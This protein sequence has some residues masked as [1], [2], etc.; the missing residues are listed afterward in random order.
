MNEWSE[1][2]GGLYDFGVGVGSVACV[3]IVL[4][5]R[6]I[7]CRMIAH[8]WH[9]AVCLRMT[10]ASIGLSAFLNCSEEVFVR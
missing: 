6:C 10:H 4:F 8:P 3:A 2:D 9:L 7:V 5:H 1:A